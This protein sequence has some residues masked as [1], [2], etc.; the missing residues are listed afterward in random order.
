MNI[1]ET[2]I[3]YLKGV[4]P[5]RGELLRKELQ[6]FTFKDLLY[7]FPF[8]Y[9][10]R[11]IIYKIRE[12]DP[13]MTYVQVI[14]KVENMET[15][16]TG[17]SMRLHVYI[18]DGTG[19]LELIWFQGLKWAKQ[20]FKSGVTYLIY[21]KLNYFNGIL[22]IPHPEVEI[23]D[24]ANEDDIKTLYPVYSSTEK[25][26][27]HG[28]GSKGISKLVKTLLPMLEGHLEE[29][30]DELVINEM[31][32]IALSK[33]LSQIHFPPDR[34]SL[35]SARLRL[36]FEELFYAQLSVL[37]LKHQR[38]SFSH[39]HSFQRVGKYFNEFYQHYLPFSLTTAQKR[40]IREIRADLR[41]PRQMNR[42][43]QG[44]V[45]SGKTLV[46]LM[47]ML[48][49]L[50]NDYQ[51][52]LMAP[53]EI[54]AQ[55][56]YQTFRKMLSGMDIEIRLLTGSTRPSER[57]EIL[58]GLLEN[59][60]QILLGT[61]ALIEEQVQF[62][63]LGLVVIDEQHR[64]GVEQRARL[65]VKNDIPPHILVMT[66]TPIPRTLAMTLYGD[67]DYSVIDEMPPGRKPVK[68][69][70][71]TDS[72]RLKVFSFMKRQIAQGRQVYV[73]YPMI[74][75]SDKLELKYLED[76][77]ISI[78]REFPL[79]HYAIS[80]V[81]GQMKPQDKEYE[82]QRFQKG[83]AQIMVSTSVIEVGVDIPN[84]TVM[85]IENAERFGLSQ[86]HQLR[87]RVGRGADESYCILMTSDKIT[88]DARARLN[89]MVKTHDGFK[90]ADVDLKLRGPGD[91][92]GTRQSGIMQ[93]RLADLS[94]DKELLDL[95]KNIADKILS[96]DPMLNRPEHTIIAQQLKGK[97]KDFMP[98]SMIS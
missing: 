63:N 75:E 89:T 6:I 49:A 56:H 30:L 69:F 15:L 79:P 17:R 73:V 9:E 33:A 45:G 53:T 67:L 21:G 59:K 94:E 26:K 50:D 46:A 36:K 47:T 91:L 18:N 58:E 62:A 20:L 80:K 71:F 23:Y 43:L 5:V 40:V 88:A 19:R 78:T 54:L 82:M 90:I 84:A 29:T 4:G 16:G 13:L 2:P 38:K 83:E 65:W 76:G 24:P 74:N 25:L 57:Q 66:A 1:L 60:V 44:D 48:I 86:L 27:S 70:L 39:G 55:Q 3:E 96:H 95:A 10:D 87:G 35:Q 32:L 68:T 61:H 52:C 72:D 8:R 85:V 64:F 28:L 97:Y 34:F 7:D 41:G 77:Y 37:Y 51:T 42:L 92:N 81:H 11:T 22:S 31:K 12:L 14:G 98:L 93:F